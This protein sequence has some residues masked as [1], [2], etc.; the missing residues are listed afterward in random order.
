MNSAGADT[1]LNF[2]KPF[3]GSNFAEAI[4]VAN[5]SSQSAG[6]VINDASSYSIIFIVATLS[7]TSSGTSLKATINYSGSYTLLKSYPLTTKGM[8]GCR[9]DVVKATAAS[10]TV[11]LTDTGS[12]NYNQLSA[13]AVL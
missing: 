13:F 9:V 7:K 1:A 12:Y 3:N 10:L 6:L 4:N 8:G 11:W 2:N 5:P